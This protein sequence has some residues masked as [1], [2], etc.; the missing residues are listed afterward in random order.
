MT[1]LIPLR[2]GRKF[3]LNYLQFFFSA[4]V[5]NVIQFFYTSIISTSDQVVNCL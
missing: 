3:L 4:A 2:R 5:R 1:A